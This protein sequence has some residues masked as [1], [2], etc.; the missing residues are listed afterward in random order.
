MSANTT[1]TT[2]TSTQSQAWGAW[3]IA[4]DVLKTSWS[5]RRHHV[6]AGVVEYLVDA[7]RK[8]QRYASADLAQAA[9]DAA[10]APVVAAQELRHGLLLNAHQAI[11]LANAMSAIN[12]VCGNFI[13][14][15][16]LPG[17]DATIRVR[18]RADG[19]LEFTR[20]AKEGGMCVVT[21]RERHESQYAFT[22]AYGLS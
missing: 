19:A 5:V 17:K 3:E 18:F 4:S 2:P 20:R 15:I 6:R 9:A 11:A 12:N 16:E 13:G 14:G 7:S 1:I 21:E 22:V 8:V 10:N